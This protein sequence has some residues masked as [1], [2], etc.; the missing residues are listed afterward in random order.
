VHCANGTSSKWLS[1]PVSLHGLRSHLNRPFV[2][3]INDLHAKEDCSVMLTPQLRCQE[4]V[5]LQED[6]SI[7]DWELFADPR[8]L[9]RRKAER[10]RGAL[11]PE[12]G[13]CCAAS[14]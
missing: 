2:R 12:V 6:G 4:L 8:A 13:S 9:E 3:Q 1:G 7:E 10:K 5:T 14:V 11:P